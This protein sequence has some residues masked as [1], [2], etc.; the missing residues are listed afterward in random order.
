MSLSGVGPYDRADEWLDV[1]AR[2]PAFVWPS[3]RRIVIVSPHPD[4]ETFGAGGLMSAALDRGLNVEVMSVTNGE[5]AYP[6]PNLAQVRQAELHVAR[7]RPNRHAI[8]QLQS[9]RARQ[10][11]HRRKQFLRPAGRILARRNRCH[12]ELGGMHFGRRSSSGLA[13]AIRCS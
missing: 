9:T 12:C 8:G 7:A 2:L 1:L 6:H 4:D 3:A 10:R 11:R 13:L 5:A